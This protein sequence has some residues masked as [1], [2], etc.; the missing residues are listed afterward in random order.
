MSLVLTIECFKCESN[1][2]LNISCASVSQLEDC[3]LDS[4][5]RT[6]NACYS[7]NQTNNFPAIGIRFT[8]DKGCAFQGE[9]EFLRTILCHDIDGFLMSCSLTCCVGDNCN[10]GSLSLPLK[11]S[12]TT[13]T[14]DT[15][16]TSEIIPTTSSEKVTEKP[17]TT[18]EPTTASSAAFVLETC[19]SFIVIVTSLLIVIVSSI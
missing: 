1:G 10:Q 14:T 4:N 6:Y 2:I 8:E 7:R 16:A 19:Q 15:T 13:A 9:C 11:P 17:K 12:P 5:G 3:G 18:S